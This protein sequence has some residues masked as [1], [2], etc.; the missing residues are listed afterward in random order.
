MVERLAIGLRLSPLKV[1]LALVLPILVVLLIVVLL[2][3]GHFL[4][5]L[6]L[7]A[8]EGGALDLAPLRDY[9]FI[10][11]TKPRLAKDVVAEVSWDIIFTAVRGLVRGAR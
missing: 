7:L 3:V 9:L 2:L 5:G 4:V 8:H 1:R 10:A 11:G 6:R